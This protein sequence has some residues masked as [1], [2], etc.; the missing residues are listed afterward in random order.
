MRQQQKFWAFAKAAYMWEKRMFQLNFL[1]KL[2]NYPIFLD[3]I[4]HPYVPTTA[5]LAEPDGQSPIPHSAEKSEEET[6][7]EPPHTAAK[8]TPT[9]ISK[10]GK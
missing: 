5:K 2:M 4:L 1:K 8:A 9:S 6:D 7:V 3:D 10:K